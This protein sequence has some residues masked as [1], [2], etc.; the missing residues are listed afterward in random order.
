MSIRQNF[1]VPKRYNTVAIVLMAIGLLAIIGLYITQGSKDDAHAN[2]RF[3]GSLLQNSV[4]FLLVTNAAMFFI[5]ATTLAWGGWQ[6][7]FRRVTEAISTCV[8]VLGVISLVV[9]LSIS[10]SDNHTIY[11]WTDTEHV[12]HDPVLLH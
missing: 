9:L 7:S 8:P 10:F 4:Y 11:H 1:E 5:C 12:K 2:A 3:W 6:M